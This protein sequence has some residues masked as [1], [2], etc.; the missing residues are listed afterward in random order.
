MGDQKVAVPAT[1][2]LARMLATTMAERG[3]QVVF[4]PGRDPAVFKVTGLRG[5]PEV[6]VIAEDDG[7]TGCFY[8]G[9]TAADA[10]QVIGRL[11]APGQPDAQVA[12]CDVQIATWDGIAVEWNYLT[13]DGQPG[14]PEHI[15]ELLLAH[16]AVIADVCRTKKPAMRAD[17]TA[18]AQYASRPAET[19]L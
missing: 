11:P 9:R 1:G 3:Y 6:E 13:P 2:A 8:I 16:L 17:D 5:N 7:F 14:D 15:T 10:A 12:T 19:P 18:A 4:P